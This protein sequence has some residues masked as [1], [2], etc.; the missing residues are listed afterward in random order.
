M[1]GHL[2]YS[3]DLTHNDFLFQRAKNKSQGLHFT[4][5]KEAVHTFKN[6]INYVQKI[7]ENV[8]K[9]S[10]WGCK[11]TY[12]IYLFIYYLYLLYIFILFHLTC[13]IFLVVSTKTLAIFS[14]KNN[15]HTKLLST[16]IYCIF[17]LLCIM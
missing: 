6:E 5:V 13:N 1:M 12:T 7:E 2:P 14:F 4:A 17:I 8:F 11:H 9:N 16:H 10:F 15:K 3:P